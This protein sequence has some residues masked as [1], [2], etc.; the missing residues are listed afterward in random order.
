VADTLGVYEFDT[1]A[2]TFVGKHLMEDGLGG[3]PFASPDGKYIVMFGRNGGRSVR[4]LEAGNP[5]KVSTVAFDIKLD[6]NTTSVEDDAVFNDFAFIQ[7]G[8]REMIVLASGNENKLVLIDPK[9]SNPSTSYISFRDGDISADGTRRQVEWAVGTNYVWVDGADASEVYIIDVGTKQVVETLTNVNSTKMVFVQN[10]ER[11]RLQNMITGES[12]FGSD[13]S[14]TERAFGANYE[15]DNDIDAVGIISLILATVALAVGVV[16]LV[17]MKNRKPQSH[18]Q[19]TSSI[20]TSSKMDE[21]VSLG[22]KNVA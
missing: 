21:E 18:G 19:P 10:Y 16:N 14:S 17:V 4:V 6:F 11:T 13:S 5:G 3:D 20:N 22:S 15:D 9:S 7:D 8:E 12:G 1:N 2:E